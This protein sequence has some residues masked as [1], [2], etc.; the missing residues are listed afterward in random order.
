MSTLTR[1]LSKV[2]SKLKQQVFRRRD[3]IEGKTSYQWLFA[4]KDLYRLGRYDDALGCFDKALRLDPSATLIWKNKAEILV[5]LGR[6]DEAIHCYE[7]MQRIK[8]SEAVKQQIQL[9]EKRLEREGTRPRSSGEFARTRGTGSQPFGERSGSRQAPRSHA[10]RHEDRFQG[11]QGQREQSRQDWEER[12]KAQRERSRRDF[13]VRHGKSPQT[14]YYDILGIDRTASQE[15]IKRAY[16][17]KMKECHPDT[18]AA[19]QD[20]SQEKALEMS[21]K[22]NEAYNVLGNVEER[23]RYDSERAP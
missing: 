10:P 5:E 9:L 1:A 14:S 15:E 17:R 18:L 6:Y 7:R 2:A 13:R 20:V 3:V 11:Q 16:R 8:P 19:E 12:A 4:G 21:K 23:R 22:V